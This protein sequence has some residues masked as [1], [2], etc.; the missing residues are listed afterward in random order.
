MN[1]LIVKYESLDTRLQKQVVYFIDYLISIKN[2]ITPKNM[3]E[4]KKKIIN[5]STWSDEDVNNINENTKIFNKWN[6][7]EF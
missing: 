3:S 7:A 1:K 5:V 2:T 4:Y 6:I